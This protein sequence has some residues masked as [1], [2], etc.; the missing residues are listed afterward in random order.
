[1]QVHSKKEVAANPCYNFFSSTGCL[2]DRC[3]GTKHKSSH[4][5]TLIHFLFS[6]PLHI[7]GSSRPKGSLLPFTSQP[8]FLYLASLPIHLCLVHE[9]TVKGTVGSRRFHLLPPSPADTW[10]HRAQD[11]FVLQSAVELLSSHT[12]RALS[13]FLLSK[14]LLLIT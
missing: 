13:E 9:C 6:Q 8:I 2:L 1:M 11:H 5:Q 7:F 14:Q 10:E 3:E 4:L 12:A